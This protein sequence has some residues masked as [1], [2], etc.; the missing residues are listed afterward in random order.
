MHPRQP[1]LQCNRKGVSPVATTSLNQDVMR[2]LLDF[3][4]ILWVQTVKA[5]ISMARHSASCWH[6]QTQMLRRKK[7]VM[8]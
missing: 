5:Q 4:Q 1:I 8:Q 3:I 6:S 7:F 2:V